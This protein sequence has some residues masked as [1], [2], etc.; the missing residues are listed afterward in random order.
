[1]IEA[2]RRDP[3]PNGTFPAS[4]W[5]LFTMLGK[6]L[7]YL[8][9][10]L[11]FAVVGAVALLVIAVGYLFSFLGRVALVALGIYA[12]DSLIDSGDS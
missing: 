7:L 11:V 3:R 9:L 2:T 10:A 12:L 1:M 8:G 6:F 4:S 5:T